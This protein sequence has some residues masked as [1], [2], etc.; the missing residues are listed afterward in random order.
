MKKLNVYYPENI[1]IVKKNIEDL[2]KVNFYP[3]LCTSLI[4]KRS[5]DEK[6][7]LEEI[8]SYKR[9][10]S[11]VPM[12]K[13][14]LDSIQG[15][16]KKH[17]FKDRILS[18]YDY[19]GIDSVNSVVN[20]YIRANNLRLD[21]LDEEYWCGLIINAVNEYFYDYY[22]DDWRYTDE[23]YPFK[24]IAN[25]TTFNSYNIVSNHKILKESIKEIVYDYVCGFFKAYRGGFE[26][27]EP[28]KEY[29]FDAFDLGFP[30]RQS[31]NRYEKNI[32]FLYIRRGLSLLYFATNSKDKDLDMA[33]D[34][35][36]KAMKQ[37]INLYHANK[38]LS[39]EFCG[40]KINIFKNKFSNV[41]FSDEIV[42]FINSLEEK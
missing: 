28:D 27:I 6:E 25:S 34:D 11:G 21:I 8:K 39:I 16:S 36:E 20:D 42:D 35:I 9:I 2:E 40:C 41:V 18:A 12:M 5:E 32:N 37:I 4:L 19:L 29:R 10:K 23:D 7:L 15:G 14:Y 13:E 3:I 38:R 22:P 1:E 24:S 17:E 30:N 33:H 26:K 31:L